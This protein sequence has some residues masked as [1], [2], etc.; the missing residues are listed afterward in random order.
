MSDFNTYT[1]AAAIGIIA[2]MRSMSTPALV[3]NHLAHNESQNL[4]GSPLSVLASSKTSSILKV[5]ALGEMVVDK[6]PI[7][8]ARISPGPLIARIVSGAI[9]GAAIC[10]A[11]DKRADV[12]AVV[13][14]MAGIL[15]AYGFYHLRRRTGEATGVP[16]VVLGVAEDAIVIGGGTRLLG[17]S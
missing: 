2:G 15:G 6:L 13:G 8:P 11:E 3:S 17:Q 7:T 12:G 16:D 1:K 5:L 10:A 14:G 9:S 4:A